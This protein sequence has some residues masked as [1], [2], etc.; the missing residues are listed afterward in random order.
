MSVRKRGPGAYQVRVD[1]FPA[2]T[3][4]TLDDANRLELDLKRRKSMGRLTL[5]LR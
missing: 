3:V 4:R 2:Q 1:P 5:R